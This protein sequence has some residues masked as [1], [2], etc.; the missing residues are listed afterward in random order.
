[1]ISLMMQ[2][3]PGKLFEEFAQQYIIEYGMDKLQK[4]A[5]IVRNSDT[6]TSYV[7]T[8]VINGRVP[9]FDEL[10]Y[11]LNSH[12]YFMWAKEET[13]CLG[14]LGVIQRWSGASHTD[15]S[16]E[17]YNLETKIMSE[18]IDQSARL[19]YNQF[20][21]FFQRYYR[22]LKLAVDSIEK[23]ELT[24]NDEDLIAF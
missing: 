18:V 9:T 5:S 20:N 13:I 12:S 22:R 11:L 10:Q 16:Q 3:G 23:P 7:Q 24:I 2:F 21:S 6:I 8:K 17:K 1:M 14:A 15:Y 19:K 4:I